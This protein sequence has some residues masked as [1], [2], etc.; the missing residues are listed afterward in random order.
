VVVGHPYDDA[1]DPNGSFE[2]L[3]L[4]PAG[5][6]SQTGHKFHMGRAGPASS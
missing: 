4:S 2:V 1:E 6:L 5:E 3:A